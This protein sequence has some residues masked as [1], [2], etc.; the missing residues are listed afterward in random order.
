MGK[1]FTH[2]CLCSPAVQIG[3]SQTWWCF[4][5]G[6]VA[7]G[8]ALHWPCVT[9]SV[10]YGLNGHR[11]GDEHP[12][13]NPSE[14]WHL[15]LTYCDKTH[16]YYRMTVLLWA[17]CGLAKQVAAVA[18][19]W[20]DLQW[21]LS[22]RCCCCCWSSSVSSFNMRSLNDCTTTDDIGL[23]HRDW[24]MKCSACSTG[25][26]PQKKKQNYRTKNARLLSVGLLYDGL[27]HHKPHLVQHDI[28][29]WEGKVC[30]LAQ[31]VRHLSSGSEGPT[32]HIFTKLSLIRFKSGPDGTR[33]TSPAIS[34]RP[35]FS[36]PWPAVLETKA[37]DTKLV[38][39]IHNMNT[40][41]KS[42]KKISCLKKP[43]CTKPNLMTHWHFGAC[44]R[45]LFL[46]QETGAR[47]WPVCHHYKTARWDT[48]ILDSH[49]D[50]KKWIY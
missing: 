38:T 12:A 40:W 2:V 47:K 20:L 29:G 45:H 1:L 50:I 13:Y 39:K 25:Q 26:G 7:I 11:K 49:D 33:H 34:S 4:G 41:K 3:T 5:A 19:C 43:I 10:V 37:K 22:D 36:R 17:G 28:L 14:V 24:F 18:S 48:L 46:V 32:P 44:F 21:E 8:L 27:W 35:E 6:K 30:W 31:T 15:Y 42:S 9:D 16:N 23:L